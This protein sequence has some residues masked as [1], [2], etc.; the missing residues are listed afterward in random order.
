METTKYSNGKSFARTILTKEEVKPFEKWLAKDGEIELDKLVEALRA[1]KET[2]YEKNQ[3]EEGTLGR[4]EKEDDEDSSSSSSTRSRNNK[5]S[6]NNKW[7]HSSAT[8]AASINGD[9]LVDDSTQVP[10][11]KHKFSLCLDDME[12]WDVRLG[13]GAWMD[14]LIQTKPEGKN[15]AGECFTNVV[16]DSGPECA[17][18]DVRVFQSG[19]V[20]LKGRVREQRESSASSRRHDDWR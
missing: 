18:A 16:Y 13:A 17:K 20:L 4:R 1:D 19:S 2:L 11:S 8:F 10:N 3:E 14:A 9:D 7:K 15:S 12:N 6:N 5:N